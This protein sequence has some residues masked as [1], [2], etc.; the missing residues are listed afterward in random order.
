MLPMHFVCWSPKGSDLIA[1]EV[2]AAKSTRTHARC[3]RRTL[4]FWYAKPL[5]TKDKSFM[6][7]HCNFFPRSLQDIGVR[8][9]KN[10]PLPSSLSIQG[11]DFN[12]PV[13][14]PILSTFKGHS[15]TEHARQFASKSS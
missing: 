3:I 13:S 8:P 1:E 12:Q 4:L 15:S 2:S 14:S 11:Q 7:R 10:T 5:W 6:W 9:S